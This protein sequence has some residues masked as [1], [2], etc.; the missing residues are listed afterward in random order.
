MGAVARDKFAKSK[1]RE[2]KSVVQSV[3][4]VVPA[5]LDIHLLWCDKIVITENDPSVTLALL[6]Y[7]EV[8]S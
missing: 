7:E 6:E 4:R 8:D 1:P 2:M 5:K 3:L